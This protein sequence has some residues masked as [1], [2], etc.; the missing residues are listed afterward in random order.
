MF[1]MYSGCYKPS[2]SS[3]CGPEFHSR[4]DDFYDHAN[5]YDVGD[6]KFDGLCDRLD[7]LSQWLRDTVRG[8]IN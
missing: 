7:V 5:D 3:A 2:D 8:W 6:Y 4:L 1:V